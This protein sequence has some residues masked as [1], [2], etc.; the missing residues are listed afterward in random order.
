MLKSIFYI[1]SIIALIIIFLLINKTSK[2]Q[3]LLLWIFNSFIL[4]FCYNIVLVYILSFLY[5]H[6]TLLVLS[7]INII[8]SIILYL[9]LIRKKTIQ[10]YY[11]NKIDVLYLIILFFTVIIIGYLR[12]DFPFKI[13]YE[14][15]DP[16]THFWTSM[17]FFEESILLNKANTAIDFSARVFGSYVNTGI[18]LKIFYPFTGYIDLYQVY[19]GFDLFMFFMSGIIFYFFIRYLLKER[20]FIIVTMASLLYLLGYPLNS[21]IFGFFYSGHIVT[22]F[23]SLLLIFKMLENKEINSK[24]NYTFITLINIGICFTYYFYTP[25]LVLAELIYFI[26]IFKMNENL[27]T[28]IIIKRILLIIGLPFLLTCLYFI[29]PYIGTQQHSIFYQFTL[30]G[31]CY[32]TWLSD[33]IL[34]LPLIVYYIISTLMNKKINL[35]MNLFIIIVAF[36]L[37][38]VILSIFNLSVH[39]YASKL[40]Y[41]LW[42]LS[43]VMLFDLYNSKMLNKVFWL[44]Y[45]IFCLIIFMYS[46][47]RVEEKLVDNNKFSINK[48]DTM[49]ILS[50]YNYNI[51]KMHSSPVTFTLSEI[52]IIRKLYD[53]NA[54]NVVNNIVEAFNHQRIWLNAF[55]W[56]EKLDY[57]ENELFDYVYA[58]SP[59]FDPQENHTYST[60]NNNYKFYVVFYRYYSE[61]KWKNYNDVIPREIQSR[62]DAN[63]RLDHTINRKNI[64]DMIDRSSCYNCQFIDFKDGVIIIKN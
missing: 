17:N 50:I 24:Y 62:W 7:I 19:I 11:I 56:R 9:T 20:K 21:L 4:L 59:F 53:L 16:G 64:Y 13:V 51:D 47:F 60:I 10:A 44:Y 55:F 39:Y 29:I 54:T 14:T 41:M 57:P 30:D 1:L 22:L 27:K 40:F 5:I 15:C 23:C 8:I 38:L 49:H 43:F 33:F 61:E 45:I 12:F 63:F 18:L 31:Y 58:E 42:L 26:Y 36:V 25:I 32:I 48:L 37:F 34:F 6:S 2:K 52:D 28:N 46:I 35:E 3:N